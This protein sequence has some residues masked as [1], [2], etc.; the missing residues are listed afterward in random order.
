[1]QRIKLCLRYIDA[2]NECTGKGVGFLI[3]PITLIITLEV[4]LRY[5]FNRPTIWAWDVNL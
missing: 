5:V 3:I 4:I 2:I 1:M